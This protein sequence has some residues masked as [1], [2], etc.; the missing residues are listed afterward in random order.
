M[1]PVPPQLPTAPPRPVLFHVAHHK[2]AL[3]LIDALGLRQHETQPHRVFRSDRAVL[4]VSGPGADNTRAA[5]APLL[6]RESFSAAVNAGCAACT[7]TGVPLG[8]VRIAA[9]V[10]CDDN[11]AQPL[12]PTP[13]ALA[14]PALPLVTVRAPFTGP[15]G[16]AARL[17]DMEGDAFVAA[18]QG[19]FAPEHIAVIKV[20]SD[21]GSDAIPSRQQVV[22]W[23]R[24][25]LPKW[26]SAIAPHANLSAHAPSDAPHSHTTRPA[27]WQQV[28]QN[29]IFGILS[30]DD[31]TAL[32]QLATQHRLSHSLWQQLLDMAADLQAWRETPVADLLAAAPNASGKAVFAHVQRHWTARKETPADY[33]GFTGAPNAASPPRRIVV[34]PGTRPGFGDCPVA[35]PKTRC[36]NLQ[37][38]DVAEGCAFRCSYCAIQAF[39][40]PDE[41]ALNSDVAQALDDLELDKDVVHHIGTGQASDSLLFGN[42]AGLLEALMH[43]ARRHPKVIL[44]LKTK[45]DN[46]GWLRDNPIPANVLCTWTLNT[47]TI[48][49]AEEHGT[50]RLDQRL[51]AA[52]DIA[53]KGALVGFHFHPIVDYR[54]SEAEYADLYRRVLATFSPDEVALVSLGTLTFTKAVV[55]QLRRTPMRSRVLQMPLHDIAQRLSYPLDTKRRM[56]RHAYQSFAPWHDRVFFYMCMEDASL[57]PEVFDFS[58]PD[59]DAFEAAMKAHYTAA[60]ARR[61]PRGGTP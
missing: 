33:T 57:W 18:V 40:E 24:A 5:L 1:T 29:P 3:A 34:R 37:T 15:P 27:V 26:L 14:L 4:V 45:S 55:R 19:H 59:N 30:E 50:A 60:I 25:E 58:Y 6:Q 54:G 17:I 23:M 9:S 53:D 31:R 32:A 52:R 22:Q 44:E 20:V 10:Q 13:L 42:R 2:E 56:F 49:D 61:Q 43:F 36:C 46:I 12:C 48:I 39:Y 21:W 47:P 38:L 51:Q 35:S 8:S 11:D 16:P 28:Q 41:I 7:D